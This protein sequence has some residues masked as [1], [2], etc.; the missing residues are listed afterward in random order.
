M[1]HAKVVKECP[2]CGARYTR[3]EWEALPVCGHMEIA[4]TLRIELRHC[5]CASTIAVRMQRDGQPGVESEDL[6]VTRP[7]ERDGLHS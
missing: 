1:P 7:P 4:L 3:A 2:C 6:R 5:T